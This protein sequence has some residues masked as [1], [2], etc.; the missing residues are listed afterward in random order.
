MAVGLVGMGAGMLL[1]AGAGP[2][3]ELAVLQTAFVMA[4][5][6]LAFN[7]GPAVGVAMSAVTADR[8][9]LASGVV[10]LAR[11][12]GITMGIAVLG[13]VLAW[14]SGESD[15]GAAFGHGVRAAVL[16]GAIVELGGAA[17]VTWY[18]RTARRERAE[19]VEEATRA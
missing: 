16:T 1:Y 14:V 18:A 11:L 12:V 10:N 15:A 7:T 5:A 2:D 4:G 17:V 8:A 3:A 13:T 6:G 19:P 9:G